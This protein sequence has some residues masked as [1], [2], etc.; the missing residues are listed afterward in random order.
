MSQG[1]ERQRDEHKLLMN[2]F[3]FI[4][5][6]NITF[7]ISGLLIVIGLLSLGIQG[8]NL[9]VDFT[10]GSILEVQYDQPVEAS[11]VESVVR[12]HPDMQRAEAVHLGEPDSPIIRIRSTAFP[13][14][15]EREDLYGDL[16]QFGEFEI[17]QLDSVSP[18][19]GEEL[20][21]AGLL[22]LVIAV[23][24]MVLYITLRF[25]IRF[26]VVT[27]VCLL[28]DALIMLGLF[29]LYRLEITSAFIAAILTII[30]YS[31]ND[32]IVVFDRIRENLR[33]RKK[34]E[35][36]I[37]TIDDSIRQVLM[38]TLATSVTTF[39]AV[40]SIFVFGGQNLRQFTL[41][42]LFGVVIGTYSS[43]FFA[44][45]LWSLWQEKNPIQTISRI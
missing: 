28:H 11:A 18:V 20:F 24:A 41:A 31:A 40:G 1:N 34:G 36:L 45:P 4:D 3:S 17:V 30:G 23:L 25:E 8:L 5:K 39:V 35:S 7:I 44:S 12:E 10:G 15:E 19:I 16:Q 33:Y 21:R 13:D 42:L 29:S 43:I 38:R 32:T 14:E 26:A 9:G 6:R 22:A 27:I 37:E 2:D